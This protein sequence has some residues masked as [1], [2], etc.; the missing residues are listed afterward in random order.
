MFGVHIILFEY[1]SFKFALFGF[2]FVCGF[3][4]GSVLRGIYTK[5]GLKLTFIIRIQIPFILISIY[6]EVNKLVKGRPV[7]NLEFMQWMKRYCDSVNGG[8]LHGYYFMFIFV[9]LF[10]LSLLLLILSRFVSFFS[11]L[12]CW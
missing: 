1:L 9:I 10:F 6:I 7:D 4:L 5:S 2:C 12:Y 8:G 11:L 3:C